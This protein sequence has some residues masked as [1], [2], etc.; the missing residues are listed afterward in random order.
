MKN[1][2]ILILLFLTLNSFAQIT[3]KIDSLNYAGIKIIVPEECTAKSQYELLECNG[4]SIQWLYLN[5]EML[6]SVPDQIIAQFTQQ[7]NTQKQGKIKLV[8]FGQE[9][10]GIKFKRKNSNKTN[11]TLVA[12]GIVNN[13]PLLINI[14]TNKEISEN[15]D[16]DEF[17]SRIIQFK[18]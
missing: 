3:E 9:L 12:Y 13:Q 14:S 15:S 4:N 17:L 6:K 8:S 11:F 5:Q 10:E 16:L 7:Q 2:S 1:I 18:K